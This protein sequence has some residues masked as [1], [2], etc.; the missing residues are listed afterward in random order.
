MRPRLLALVALILALAASLPAAAVAQTSTTTASTSTMMMV[1]PPNCNLSLPAFCDMFDEGLYSGTAPN[2]GG[3]LDPT[4][5]SFARETSAVN[6][7]QG[8][9]NWIAPTDAQFCQTLIHNVLPTADSFMCDGTNGTDTTLRHTEQ[10]HWME[11][12][13]DNG[14]Y[15]AD[16][17]RILQPFDFAGRTGHVAF[18]VDAV[19]RGPHS[20]WPSV[21]ISDQPVQIPHD[22]HPGIM[23]AMPRNGVTIDLDKACG[24]T[25]PTTDA[26]ATGVGNITLYTDYQATPLL[27]SGN[28]AGLCVAT[29]RDAPNEVTVAI[30]ASEI[31]VYGTDANTS[32]PVL[33]LAQ[34][35]GLSL[36]FARGYVAVEHSQYNAAKF[37]EEKTHTY[38]WHEIGF[39]GPVLPTP[40]DVQVPDALTPQQEPQAGTLD[41]GAGTSTPASTVM[42]DGLNT[43]YEVAAGGSRAF[44]LTGIPAGASSP[45]LTLDA[46]EMAYGT[47]PA[48]TY[49]LN[50]H[51][52]HTLDFPPIP[53]QTD[54]GMV[55]YLADVDP[56]EL[57][58]GSNTLTFGGEADTI[59]ANI[60]LQ[61]TAPVATP[62]ATA[63][64]TPP[65]PVTASTAST[66]AST[67]TA[68]STSTTSQGT[69][70]VTH[71]VTQT[72]TQT[73]T[74]STAFTLACTRS[75]AAISCAGQ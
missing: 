54:Y 26:P 56:T 31:D 69:A 70:T 48:I 34:A 12:I 40:L 64:S 66:T 53:A 16:A 65:S 32:S 4:R 57:V 68:P 35:T 59:L 42:L 63:T 55:A 29:G 2:R 25:D 50:G 8:E 9:F 5:W 33:L 67:S 24:Q 74:V 45:V 21:V 39:D 47:L 20:W 52:A 23:G 30:S 37:N 1:M 41:T 60:D 36:P 14:E 38:H 22:N 51:T 3:A 61:L 49:A 72:I 13:N 58:A 46:R 43:G 75:G 18:M 27:P 73:V 6:P 19:T 71:T 11:A 62:T 10:M 15:Q 44:T 17:A 28:P 7:G